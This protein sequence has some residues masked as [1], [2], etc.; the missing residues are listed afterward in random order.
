MRKKENP[1][2]RRFGSG[3]TS[4]TTLKKAKQDNRELRNMRGVHKARITPDK[5]SIELGVCWMCWMDLT[6]EIL[7][8][9]R[10]LPYSEVKEHEDICPLCGYSRWKGRVWYPF[11]FLRGYIG[12]PSSRRGIIRKKIK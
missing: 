11:R 5:Y 2:W 7:E 8:K 12:N 1:S 3:M 4:P 6:S 9:W 10:K